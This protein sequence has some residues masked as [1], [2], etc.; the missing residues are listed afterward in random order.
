MFAKLPVLAVVALAG[1]LLAAAIV[2]LIGWWS[3]VTVPA[4]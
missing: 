3:A 4:G 2:P 1:A